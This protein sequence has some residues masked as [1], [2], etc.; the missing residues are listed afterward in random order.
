MSGWP[1]PRL[2]AHRGGGALAPE[3]TLAAFDVGARHGYR[4][5]EVDAVLSADSVPVLLH[6]A[7]LER[8]T[9]G[10]GCVADRTAAELMLLDAGS[11][12][13][14]EF[15]GARIPTLQQALRHCADLGVWL[16]VEIKPVAGH[17]ARTGALV[18][19]TVAR[20]G[21]GAPPL[22]SSFSRVALA[23]ARRA[24]PQ[25][26]RALL[27]ESIPTDWEKQLDA[28]DC[29]ALH[30]S[31]RRLAAA[32]AGR[33]KAAGYGLLCYTVNDVRR[34]AELWGWGVDA[35]CT[36]CIDAIGPGDVPG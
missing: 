3:N 12:F 15:A 2:L 6:D 24:A 36:D 26:P 21:A 10:S 9:D 4:A 18:A 8:T 23:A 25:L 19:E 7:G 28:L 16:N 31:H 32:Q 27:C 35:I 11:W 33:V 20:Y 1:Y 22:L 34:A 14:Q 29:V 17:E 30:C 13:G 5:A